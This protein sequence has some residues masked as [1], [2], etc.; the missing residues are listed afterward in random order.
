MRRLP[1]TLCLLAALPACSPWLFS[2]EHWVDRSRPVALVETQGGIELAATTEFGV[3]TLGRSAQDGPCKVHYFL[4][5]TPLTEAGEV[6]S[7]GTVFHLADIDLKTQRAR[8]LDREP[9]P[10]DELVAIWMPDPR[11]SVEVPVRLADHPAVSGAVL[12]GDGL[13]LPPGT[14]GLPAGAAIFC[15]TDDGLRFVGLVAG[16]ATL[17]E[18]GGE[19]TFYVFAGLDRVKELLAIPRE[20]PRRT[21]PKF[22]YDDLIVDRPV[23]R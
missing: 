21:E 14:P 22:R 23:R 4:G 16:R 20:H 19:R 2:G 8:C 10:G 7:T 11:S 5:P 15:Q 1:T 9:E 18:A 12:A 3:L 17:Q 6:V 13:E